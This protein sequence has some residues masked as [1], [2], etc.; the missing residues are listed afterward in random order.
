MPL[1]H[2]P[3]C[4]LPDVERIGRPVRITP[5]RAAK[6]LRKYFDADSKMAAAE[7]ATSGSAQVSYNQLKD[8]LE[9]LEHDWVDHP[10]G[11]LLDCFIEVEAYTEVHL[12]PCFLGGRLNEGLRR[13]A[14]EILLKYNR[15]LGCI[16]L[17]M[18]D[19]R[20]AGSRYGACVSDGPYVHFLA[21]FTSIGF[22]P[23]S[24]GWVLGRVASL[25]PY[26]DALNVGVLN[27]INTRVAKETLPKELTYDA[28]QRIWFNGDTAMRDKH[29]VLIKLSNVD[30]NVAKQGDM[31]IEITGSVK[32]ATHISAKRRAPKESDAPEETPKAK[33]KREREEQGEDAGNGEAAPEEAPKSK[34]KRERE[35]EGEDAPEQTPK[36]NRKRERDTEV[37]NAEGSVGGGRVDVTEDSVKKMK[38]KEKREREERE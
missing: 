13:A 14:S 34:R 17:T 38:K 21:R 31:G 2:T 18:G 23:R 19:F 33:R 4:P 11:G 37:D 1:G 22:A 25:Q 16:P 24:N 5:E 15:V 7:L 9:R 8:I 26:G 32:S 10:D 27:L 28:R 20:P 36:S 3:W 35:T 12:H 6:E 29:C 30:T